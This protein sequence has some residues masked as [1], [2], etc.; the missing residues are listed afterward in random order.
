MKNIIRLRLI[1]F[2]DHLKK[3]RQGTF[4][5]LISCLFLEI[6][7]FLKHADKLIC[8][9]IYSRIQNEICETKNIA[10]KPGKIHPIFP[11]LRC[12]LVQSFFETLQHCDE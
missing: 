3:N 7:I 10:K 5:F 2:K 9:V 6:F 11:R 1:S 4:S 8:D 12:F